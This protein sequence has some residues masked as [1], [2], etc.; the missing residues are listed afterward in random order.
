MNKITIVLFDYEDE[1]IVR[2]QIEIRDDNEP[3]KNK[4][5]NEHILY[6][7]GFYGEQFEICKIEILRN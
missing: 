7:L 2:E 5:I 6:L 3:R 4:L 1:P